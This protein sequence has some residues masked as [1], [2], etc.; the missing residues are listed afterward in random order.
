M[1]SRSRVSAG[2]T[3]IEILVVIV[4]ISVLATL[5]APNVFQHVGRSKQ[6]VARSQIELLGAALDAYRLDNDTYPATDQGLEALRREPLSEPRPRNWRGPYLRKE[7]PL[8]PWGRPY[9]YRSPG[10]HSAWG[11]D[12]VSYGRDGR[13]GGEGED[14]DIRSWE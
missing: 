3:L 14:A 12:L 11:Y 6:A 5:V 2:F 7:V 4:V 10:V 13:E 9:L 8:D 1:S